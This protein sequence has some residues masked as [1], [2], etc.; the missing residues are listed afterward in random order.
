MSA[1]SHGRLQDF[2]LARVPL[3]ERRGV[4]E[5]VMV[6]LG[7]L[8]CLP[9]FMMGAALGVG[10]RFWDAFWAIL[11]G[12]VLLEIVSA[13]IGIAGAR[14]GVST[15]VLSRWTGFGRVGTTIL[16]LVTAISGIGWFGVQNTVFAEGL[17]SAF[18]G[19]LGMVAANIIAAAVVVVIV[20]Y[21]FRWLSWTATIAVPGFL[22]VVA[23]GIVKMFQGH[24][25]SSLIASAPPGA[26]MSI[27]AGATVVAGAF[28]VGA[29]ATPDMTRYMRSAR[30]VVWMTIIS[31]TTGEI[32][33]GMTAVL[34]AHATGTSD[35]V[36]ILL[37]LSGIVGG[38]MVAFST[39]K[40][41]DWNL[42]APSL[43]ITNLWE[44]VFGRPINRA[45]VTVVV[46]A[47]GTALAIG[48]I[49]NLFVPFLTLLGVTLPPVGGIMMADYFILKTHRREL[50]ATREKG[51]LP[52]SYP[53]VNVACLVAWA[54]G[55]VAGKVITWGIPSLTALIIGGVVYVVLMK[56]L[57]AS[58]VFPVERR[59]T[60]VA[61]QVD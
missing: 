29:I 9:L 35:V 15:Y 61:V 27:G 34:M 44:S 57:P 2:A 19:H 24:S 43:A 45:W 60:S 48:G 58:V 50:E 56:V 52:Q 1:H 42:Y 8:A 12:T 46:G 20:V 17:N 11:L 13:L 47:L 23:Y 49:L 41:N 21:G 22:V 6:R 53:T 26:A 55:S 59:A 54:I 25:L 14:E 3:S 16:S 5:M 31:F 28:M 38:L 18:G 7:Q 37:K 4:G 10:M 51:E 32:L 36:T 40:I 33:L 30:D 39:I